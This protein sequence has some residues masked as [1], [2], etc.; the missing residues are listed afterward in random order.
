MSFESVSILVGTAQSG[1]ASMTPN[2]TALSASC[3]I[4]LG[5]WKVGM[6]VLSVPWDAA[7][8]VGLSY[9]CTF[10]CFGTPKP[11]TLLVLCCSYSKFSYF[12]LFT[13]TGETCV[14][15]ILGDFR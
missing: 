2:T 9:I 10:C 14:L 12:I 6:L 11:Y 13:S 8:G 15:F 4:F 3:V 7:E 5:F 1:C